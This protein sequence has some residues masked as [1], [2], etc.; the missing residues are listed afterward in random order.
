MI[1]SIYKIKNYMKEMNTIKF[2]GDKI[3]TKTVDLVETWSKLKLSGR[4]FITYKK[5]FYY[6][7]TDK[8]LS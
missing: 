8:K 4:E 6:L 3:V 1:I 2:M 7:V 5:E